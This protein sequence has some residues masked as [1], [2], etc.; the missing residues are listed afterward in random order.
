M[1][2]ASWNVNGIRARLDHV[3]DWLQINQPD[4]LTLQET[5]VMDEMFPLDAFKPLG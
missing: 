4:V 2:I 1:K 3:S 5:K